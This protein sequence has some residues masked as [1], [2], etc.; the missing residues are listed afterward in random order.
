MSGLGLLRGTVVDTRP[1]RHPDFR[2]LWLGQGVSFIGFQLT[3]VA[4]PVEVYAITRSSLWVGLLGLASLVPLIIFGLWGGT[5]A[6]A[7]DRRK[8]LLVASLCTWISTLGLLTQSLLR[9]DSVTVIFTLI[10]IQ[11]IGFAISSPTRSAIVPRLVPQELV[12]S[13][14]TLNFIV[15]NF[16]TVA[17]PLI[18][19]VVLARIGYAGAYA[20]DAALFT[21]GLY[22]AL[23]LPKLAPLGDNITRPGLRSLIDGLKFIGV[24][25]VLIMSFVVDIIAMVFAMPKA[26]F[27]QIAAERFGGVDA[28]GWLYSSIAIGSVVAGLASGWIGR[29]RKQGIALVIAIFFWGVAVAAAGFSHHLWITVLLLAVGGGADLV[30]AVYRQTILQTYAPDE[31]RGRMQGVFTVVVAGGPRLADLRAG[32]M[33]SATGLSF[34]WIGGGI[35]CSIAVVLALFLVPALRHYTYDPASRGKGLG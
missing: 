23:R 18:A 32:A 34:A 11:S 3:S 35:A 6:D 28:T 26:L 25:P 13:A 27:P 24:R 5:V 10:V 1:L 17:G 20:I 33:A 9:L 12:P 15:S 22:A 2:R 29:V 30:S 21:A 4:V 14:N 19:G 16:G 7:M 31:M 8:L